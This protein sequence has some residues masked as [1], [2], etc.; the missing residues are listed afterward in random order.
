MSNRWTTDD[1]PNLTGKVAI[2]TGANL[3]TFE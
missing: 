2:V 1:I 3:V